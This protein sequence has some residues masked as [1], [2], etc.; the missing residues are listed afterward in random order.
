MC[1]YFFNKSHYFLTQAAE[2]IKHSE[3]VFAGLHSMCLSNATYCLWVI[4][5]FLDHRTVST[6][7]GLWMLIVFQLGLYIFSKKH[8]KQVS[9]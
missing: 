9:I 1:I 5:N 4:P 2:A 3:E 7:D 8:W 6:C